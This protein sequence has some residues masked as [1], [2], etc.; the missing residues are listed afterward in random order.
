MQDNRCNLLKLKTGRKTHAQIDTGKPMSVSEPRAKL[1][2]QA[3][4]MKAPRLAK[5]TSSE[6]REISL[7]SGAYSQVMAVKI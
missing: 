4:V 5:T 3:A 7:T 2:Q 1:V 6:L